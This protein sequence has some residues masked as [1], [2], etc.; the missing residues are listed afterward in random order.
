M[1]YYP[2]ILIFSERNTKMKK[3]LALALSALLFVAAFAVPVAA[4]DWK[5]GQTTN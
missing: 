2:K 4:V 3:F 5:D 1:G